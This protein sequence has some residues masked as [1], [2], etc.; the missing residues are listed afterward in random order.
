M[1]AICEVWGK[2]LY[3]KV[4]GEFDPIK[5]RDVF[6]EWTEFA[7]SHSLNKV[8]CDVTQVMGFDAESSSV[9]ARFAS[10]EF[11]ARLFPKGLRLS[12][13]ETTRQL[14]KDGFDENMLVNRGAMVKVTH[15]LQNALEWLG[16]T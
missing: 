4:I 9:I 15:N 10:S 3:V 8:L 6:S 14:A 5:A 16:M 13:L 11:I 12:I 1:I 2:Y 7:R